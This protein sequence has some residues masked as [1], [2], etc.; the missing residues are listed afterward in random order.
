MAETLLTRL[1]VDPK[2]NLV[3]GFRNLGAVIFP[4][5]KNLFVAKC[6]RKRDKKAWPKE[7]KLRKALLENQELDLAPEDIR[8]KYKDWVIIQAL[9]QI[10]KKDELPPEFIRGN[11]TKEARFEL[12]C[13]WHFIDVPNTIRTGLEARQDLENLLRTITSEVAKTRNK[14]YAT[15]TLNRL[16]E[17]FQDYDGS[18]FQEI[19][20]RIYE[21]SILRKV[22]EPTIQKRREFADSITRVNSILESETRLVYGKKGGSRRV[23]LEAKNWDFLKE[24]RMITADEIFEQGICF[25][26]I[27]IPF[28]RRKDAKISWVG[29]SFIKAGRKRNVIYTLYD[30]KT[31]EI[32]GFEIKSFKTEEDLVE[33]LTRDI[34][35]YNPIALSA[36]N[37]KFYLTKLRESRAGFSVGEDETS[38][39]YEVT[40]S[41]FERLGVRDRIV[42]DTMRWQKKA[43][44][45]DINAKLELTAGIKKSIS[46]DEMEALEDRIIS[47]DVWAGREIA[48]YLAGDIRAGVENVLLTS[49]FRDS[50]EDVLFIA[51]KF[52]VSPERLMHSAKCINEA[53]EVDYFHELGI[54]REEIP[55]NERTTRMQKRREKARKSFN[56]LVTERAIKFDGRKGLFEDAYKVYIPVGD[57]LRDLVSKR[58][59]KAQEFYRYRDEHRAE[60]KRLFFLEQYSKALAEWLIEGYGQY[61]LNLKSLKERLKQLPR[62]NFEETY[63]QLRSNI[64]RR[65]DLEALEKLNLAKFTVK[66]LSRFKNKTLDEL[67]EN[68]GLAEKHFVDLCN[69]RVKLGRSARWIIGNF[70]VYPTRSYYDPLKSPEGPEEILVID[71]IL[72]EK[73]GQIN[74]FISGSELE[75]IAQEGAY[76]YVKPRERKGEDKG[77]AIKRVEEALA[78]EDAPIILVDKIP[79]LYN[80]DNPY[81]N[82]L[83]Y[84]THIKV[85]DTPDFRLSVFEMEVLGN[86]LE[87]L[88]RGEEEEALKLYGSGLDRLTQDRVDPSK[89]VFLNK[90]KGYRFL[91]SSSPRAD[92]Q[93]KL[94]FIEEGEVPKNSKILEEKGERYIIP[95]VEDEE[96][97]LGL[98]WDKVKK[99]YIMTEQEATSMLDRKRYFEKFQERAR[100]ILAPVSRR[101][102]IKKPK[103]DDKQMILGL[104]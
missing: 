54:F 74:N 33:A 93:G 45:F 30:L 42:L 76:L 58:F 82:K 66:D 22:A 79:R 20:A 43:R 96:D 65:R 68:N 17:V 57:I 55:P 60:K 67:L 12:K 70:Q 41:F 62:K 56:D 39:L 90:S 36:H 10:S 14:G 27:E 28:W 88:L 78:R 3:A 94:Y 31:P 69:H 104:N 21:D 4:Y 18:N 61:L 89:L 86:M 35:D 71:E 2:G 1:E 102:R 24:G 37:H 91:Y 64:S 25:L 99:V 16:D 44:A 51:E 77:V 6:G 52:N 5:W 80:A 46:Y 19:L 83:G 100:R 103:Y 53:Q 85:K 73:F 84:W 34:K 50:L 49:E 92:K 26:D 63:E 9:L 95:G 32:N 72:K 7:M 59:P 75:V 15:R 13:P 11:Y 29:T 23:S 47:G 8:I 38:P 87:L 98:D 81:Y 48:R 101:G 40:T 97:L